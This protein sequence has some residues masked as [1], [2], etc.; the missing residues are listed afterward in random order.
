MSADPK[1]LN[2]APSISREIDGGLVFRGVCFR[3]SAPAKL[4]EG[5]IEKRRKSS[6]SE[7]HR[8]LKRKGS[9]KRGMTEDS[10]VDSIN[11]EHRDA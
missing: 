2:K 5:G 3:E 6:T 11:D 7:H 4:L 9:L 8:S 1:R 10:G